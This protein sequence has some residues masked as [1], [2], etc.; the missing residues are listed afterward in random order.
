[1]DELVRP[2]GARHLEADS[3]ASTVDEHPTAASQAQ[4][5]TIVVDVLGPGLRG[6]DRRLD[7]IRRRAAVNGNQQLGRGLEPE[8]PDAVGAERLQARPPFSCFHTEISYAAHSKLRKVN[9]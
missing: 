1:M 5:R 8:Q 7:E 6:A 4:L 3:T 9:G 2:H